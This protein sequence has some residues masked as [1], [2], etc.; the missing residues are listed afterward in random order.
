MSDITVTV[1]DSTS[2]D[3]NVSASTAVT[4]NSVASSPV[5]VTSKGAKGDTGAA[6][7][8]GSQGVAGADGQGVPTGGSQFQ[9]L[10]KD[11]SD[12]YDT[13]WAFADRVTI[14]V[15]FDEAVSKGD[16]L[17]ITGYNNGQNRITVA[18][19]DASDSAKMPS[20]GLAFADYSQNDNGQATT[21]G[22]LEDI[23]TQVTYDFQEGDVVY[24]ASGGG[25]T[26]VKPTGT[27]LIQNVGKVGRRQQNNGEIVVMA[28][29]R[30]NDVPN[31]PNGQIWIGN[32]SGVATPTAFGVDLD[33]SPQ[34]GGNLDTNNNNINFGDADKAVFGADSNIQ[35]YHAGS[36][37]NHIVGLAGDSTYIT[38]GTDLYLRGVNGEEAVTI[39]GNGS[40]ELFHDNSKKLETTSTGIDVTGNIV[41]SGTVDGVDISSI[42]DTTL[43]D[44]DVTLSGTR[45]INMNGNDFKIRDGFASKLEYDDS[46]DE[47]IF[48]APV[49]FDQSTGGEIKLRE[50]SQGGTSG[51]VLKAPSGNLASDIEFRL[52]AADGSSGQVIKTDGSGNLSFVD[53]TTNTDTTLDDTDVVLSGARNINTNGNNLTIKDGLTTVI[54][55]I[56][57][58]SEISLGQ[59]TNVQAKTASGEL[60]FKEI[61]SNGTNHVSLKAPDS[62]SADASFVLPSADGSADEFLKTDGSGNLSFGNPQAKFKQVY[63]QNFLDDI[64]TTKHY[65]PFKDINEQTTIY[66]EEAAML[67]PYD[68]RIES[69]SIRVSA[70]TGAGNFTVGVHTR[71]T[72]VSQFSASTWVTEEEEVLAFTATDDYHTFHFVFD[73]ASHFEAGDLCSISLQAS[74]DPS[75]SIYVYVTTVVEFDTSATLGQSSANLGSNP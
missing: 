40:V 20:I 58:T 25:L 27:N 3:V 72:G 52:P 61:P 46:A 9:I 41:V 29:G 70:L 69:V 1:Q 10:R 65:L 45:V 35:I 36:T 51:V 54:S 62:L 63:L 30:S 26:N 64:A 75:G 8:Q 66:Q 56:D 37:I 5:A 18:K 24:V 23:D 15:R 21:I 4:V 53:Q 55:Y 14:E 71:E 31:I 13:S 74:S 47:W 17:Y 32:A 38:G 43:D 7:P 49:R 34:L 50:A 39:N 73:D 59:V 11:T 28:I 60:R 6:G 16:P 67:M 12:D 68:G 2:V 19:A 22:S 48:G 33:S 42:T 57:G 44:T